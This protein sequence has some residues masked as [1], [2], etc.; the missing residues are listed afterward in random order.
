MCYFLP[1][2]KRNQ[3]YIYMGLPGSTVGKKSTSDAGDPSSVP[4]SERSPG[5]GNGYP[6]H[7]FGLDNSM[8]FV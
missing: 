5:E 3:P 7:Y 4:G 8:V 1:Y 2:D 6:L